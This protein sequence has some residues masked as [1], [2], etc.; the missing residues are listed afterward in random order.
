[1]V[2]W[3]HRLNG[4]ESEQ[5]LGDGEGQGSLPSFSSWGCRESDT[6]VRLDNNNMGL[7]K[8]PGEVNPRIAINKS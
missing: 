8:S 2:G 5:A 7:E 4:H 1:M 3:Y 6:T